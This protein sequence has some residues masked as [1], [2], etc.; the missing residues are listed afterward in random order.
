MSVGR[1]AVPLG[2]CVTDLAKRAGKHVGGV[3][4]DWTRAAE[5][6]A[7]VLAHMSLYT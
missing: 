2:S 3:Y 7:G 5:K 6:K 4:D 1:L